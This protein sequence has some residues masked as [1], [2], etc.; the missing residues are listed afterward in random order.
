MIGFLTDWGYDSYYVGVTKAVIKSI[1]P[2]ADIVDITHSVDAFDIKKGAYILE[3]ATDDFPEK[4]VFLAVVDPSVGTARKSVVI[5]TKNGSTFVG[6]DNGL[7]TFVIEKFGVHEIRE[8]E[9]KEFF[10]GDSATFH[11]REIFAPVAGH[12]ENGVSIDKFGSRLMTYE[13]LRY[14]APSFEAGTIT[15]EVAFCDSF[16]NIE[17]NIPGNLLSGTEEGDT[18][19]LKNGKKK[20]PLTYEKTYFDVR[21]GE[22]LFHSDS[23][24]YIEIAV[25]KGNA[26]ETFGIGQGD[27]VEIIK[28]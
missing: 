22:G 10:Y 17:T 16:G 28:G 8:L 7:F 20:Y 11:G 1:C 6:P 23:S 2:G 15:G 26:R 5:K 18:F 3:R 13:V 4:S 25:N 14:K 24:G 12:I 19:I 21:K 9:N 27:L